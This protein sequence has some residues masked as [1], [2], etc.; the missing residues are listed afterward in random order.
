MNKNQT[1]NILKKGMLLL[2]MATMTLAINAVPAKP[3]LVR[4]LKLSD[5][6]TVQARLV[7]DEHG[8]YWLSSNGKAYRSEG[9]TEIFRSVDIQSVKKVAE[10]RRK[11]A[12][13]RRSNR[14]AAPKKVGNV[15][16][17]TGK[18]KGIIILVNF[19]DVKFQS[20]NNNALYQRIA[21][22]R[23]FSYGN[24]KGSMYDYFYAQSEGQFEL[25][26]DVVGPVT[27]SMAQSYYGSNDSQGND[28]FP[29]TMVI[30]A[31]KKAD[32]SVN[33]ADYDW[34]GD[35]YVDQVYVVYAGKG[36]AD[37][38]ASTTIWPHEWSLSSASYYGDG[39]GT[40][41]LDG[42]KI[43]TYACGGELNGSTGTIAGIGTM[44]HEFSH[45]LGY[46]DFYDTDY[47]GGQ[48]MGEWDLMDSGSY[49]GDGYQPSG[50]TSYERWV[51]GWKEPITLTYSTAVTGMKSLQNG[52]ESYIIYNN[53]NNNEFYLLENRQKQGWDASLPGAGLL[54][55]HVDY[56]ES[57]WSNNQPNDDP[58]HQR[59]TWIPAD[60]Q[61]QYT[62][63]MG[64]RYYSSEG[65]AN[66][67]FPYGNVNSFGKN[68]T[69]AAKLY[70][71]NSD[72]SYYLDSSVE[73]ITQ[74][75]DKTISF[76]FRGLSLVAPPTFT[77]AAGAY[78]DAVQVTIS[79]AQEG[80]V[81]YYTVDGST[82]TTNS[83]RYT[84]PITVESSTTIKAISVADGE[85]SD[86]VTANYSIV[87]PVSG[88][89]MYK[90][91]T[92]TSEIVSG[93]KYIIACGSKS[94]AASSLSSNYLTSVDVTADGDFIIVGENTNV[95]VFTLTGSGTSYKLAT[96]DGKYLNATAEK[97]LALAT[98]GNNWTLNDDA[99]GV[100]LSYKVTSS[101]WWGTTT[102]DYGTILYNV[103]SPRFLNYK[104]SP[105]NNMIYA[106]LYMEYELPKAAPTL[107]FSETEINAVEGKEFVTP[108]LTV[109]P[110]DLTVTYT[111]SNTSVATVNATTGA[112]TLVGSGTTIITATSAATETHYSGSASYTLN[113]KMEEVT[114]VLVQNTSQLK[115]KDMIIIVAENNGNYYALGRTQNNRN[116]SAVSVTPNDD[117][118]ISSTDETQNIILEK[119]ENGW[120]LNVGNGYLCSSSSSSNILA[121]TE[122]NTLS[123]TIATISVENATAS[124]KFQDYNRN[125][126]RFNY[127]NGNPIFACY[128]PGNMKAV[129]IYRKM[130]AVLGDV[131]GD[132]VVSVADV[133][134]AVDYVLE[135]GDELEV[136]IFENADI[137][138]DGT[139]SVNDVTSIVNMILND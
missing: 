62:T 99:S 90:R 12:N 115:D 22:E 103:Q 30:D 87:T 61:Y 48:G 106:N 133:S 47:S 128:A 35:G 132:G 117:N 72:G 39:S 121:T 107:S 31:C 76:N 114:Y 16:N 116:R 18:K 100:T 74:N 34:D 55:L 2:W 17:Y 26:F 138:G 20:A 9:N 44:C 45:C 129:K 33:F 125:D 53:G 122:D 84:G 51:A 21:N 13:S 1:Y 29:A 57:V 108:T 131:N 124:I 36:E 71:K 70:N 19:A 11:E 134:L 27:V 85:S 95:N 38:G 104:S 8:H 80:A 15:G 46:P 64:T 130:K 91:V 63:Y 79:C 109:T 81:I 14:L 3:G 37:G 56:D 5:G 127:N 126:L 137:D 96:Q 119:T 58:S 40:L 118:S 86:V 52:G 41:T 75:S 43:D 6:T 73:D 83:T 101:S 112:I 94:K 28:K 59:M 50:Y 78:T 82:P 113:V 105:N 7:G 111:S 97:K 10:T 24:F 25:E 69:P 120:Q 139:I 110:S 135:G 49:N 88:S 89:T 102:T 136:F 123:S 65:M 68:T 98:T 66:D 93:K 77:P 4:T 54:I 32:S 23:N 42:V 67:P 92:S 60:N